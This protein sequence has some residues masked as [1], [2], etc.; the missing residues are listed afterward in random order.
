MQSTTQESILK[1]NND[2]IHNNTNKFN[3]EVIKLVILNLKI[4]SKVNKY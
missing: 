2:F 4:S 1:K 3:Y